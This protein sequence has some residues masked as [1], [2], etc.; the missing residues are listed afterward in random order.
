MT[1]TII[2]PP[3]RHCLTEKGEKKK[4]LMNKGIMNVASNE[5]EGMGRHSFFS[6]Q[7]FPTTNSFCHTSTQTHLNPRSLHIHCSALTVRHTARNRGDTET[8]KEDPFCTFIRMHSKRHTRLN[9]QIL[10]CSP[11]RDWCHPRLCSL[12]HSFDVFS[13]RAYLTAAVFLSYCICFTV[14]CRCRT[15]GTENEKTWRC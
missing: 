5:E 14:S 1:C 9:P 3:S 4:N 8:K 6:F 15:S 2:L 7:N 12:F 13:Q 10:L 11:T